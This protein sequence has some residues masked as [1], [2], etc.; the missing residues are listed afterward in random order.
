MFSDWIKSLE[1]KGV[2]LYEIAEV[3]DVTYQTI[4]CYRDRNNYPTVKNLIKLSE[5]YKISIEDMLYYN[6]DRPVACSKDYPIAFFEDSHLVG[7]KTQLPASSKKYEEKLVD[8]YR[9]VPDSQKAKLLDEFIKLA[10]EETEKYV[11]A[12]KS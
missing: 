2:K 8:I 9:K 12:V 6:E 7:G 10:S 5:H 3:I 4:Q 11:K 1:N